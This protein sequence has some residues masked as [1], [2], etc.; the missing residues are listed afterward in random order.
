MHEP[1][2]ALTVQSDQPTF[3][4]Q[5]FAMPF[6]KGRAALRRTKQWLERG[7]IMLKDNVQIVTF[8]YGLSKR[9]GMHHD[10]LE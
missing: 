6:L 2:R 8:G 4:V 10:G 7:E 1:Q 9:H 5:D 3:C